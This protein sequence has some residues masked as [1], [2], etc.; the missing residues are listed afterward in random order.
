MCPRVQVEPPP[1]PIDP[2]VKEMPARLEGRKSRIL[3]F[4]VGA[5]G[6]RIWGFRVVGSW[7]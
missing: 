7:V 6:C 3:G 1:D 5:P 4:S 2:R